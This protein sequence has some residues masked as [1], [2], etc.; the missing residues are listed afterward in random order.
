MVQNIEIKDVDWKSI[1]MPIQKEILEYVSKKVVEIFKKKVTKIY[2]INAPF[3]EGNYVP[4]EEMLSAISVDFY[5]NPVSCKIFIDED[6]LSWRDKDGD[7]IHS[8]PFQHIYEPGFISKEVKALREHWQ[9]P[10]GGRQE[11]EWAIIETIEEVGSF[12]KTEL[13]TFIRNRLSQKGGTK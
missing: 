12:F 6:K 2:E 11:Q 8:I 10:I 4:L 3:L 1:K 13:V 9:L 5:N 7:A